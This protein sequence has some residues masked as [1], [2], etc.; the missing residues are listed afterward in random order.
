M[1]PSSGASK[2]YKKLMANRSFNV[3]INLFFYHD[4]EGDK[5]IAKGLGPTDV[6]TGSFWQWSV[7]EI[8]DSENRV[9]NTQSSIQI[10]RP[11]TQGGLVALLKDLAVRLP[12]FLDENG[13]PTK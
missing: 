11:L 13:L 5:I 10:E 4:D 1:I 12:R 3:P 9:L 7:G 8:T 6:V 2:G